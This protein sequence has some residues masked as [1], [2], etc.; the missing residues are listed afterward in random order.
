MD[1]QWNRISSWINVVA[2]LCLVSGF[3][4][5][6]NDLLDR[7]SSFFASFLFFVYGAVAF[8]FWRAFAIIVKAAEYYVDD[9]EGTSYEPED[10]EDTETYDP[11][12]E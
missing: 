8:L 11:S 10:T 9:K 7:D 2:A 12:N 3:I 5:F 4:L 1:F 6:F